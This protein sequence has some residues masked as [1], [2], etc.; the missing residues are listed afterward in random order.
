MEGSIEILSLV[1]YRRLW[2][3]R[4]QCGSTASN[5]R[6]MSCR[7]KMRRGIV[8]VREIPPRKRPSHPQFNVRR[9]GRNQGASR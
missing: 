2:G 1:T 9:V 8:R 4:L 7:P 5:A 3:N 6:R